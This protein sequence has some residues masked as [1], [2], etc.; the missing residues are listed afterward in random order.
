M[1]HVAFVAGSGSDSQ[2]PLTPVRLSRRNRKPPIAADE[3]PPPLAAGGWVRA[4]LGYV[5]NVIHSRNKIVKMN[6]ILRIG[7][8]MCDLFALVLQGC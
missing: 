6:I 7:C 5:L 3:S 4:A 1:F 2:D 8:A